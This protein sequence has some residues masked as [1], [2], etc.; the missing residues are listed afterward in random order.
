MASVEFPFCWTGLNVAVIH[1][2]TAGAL[3]Y[4][5][6]EPEADQMQL[7]LLLS[8]GFATTSSIE[9]PGVIATLQTWIAAK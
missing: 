8:E 5:Q 6:Q 1:A 7:L 2:L 4:N 9:E 3:R